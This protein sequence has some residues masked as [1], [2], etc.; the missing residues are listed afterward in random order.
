MNCLSGKQTLSKLK[1]SPHN[2]LRGATG[3]AG[4]YHGG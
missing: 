3:G 1:L 4:R 2:D